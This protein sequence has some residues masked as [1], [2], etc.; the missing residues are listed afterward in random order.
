MHFPC[1]L[2]ESITECWSNRNVHTS[3]C[4]RN[5]QLRPMVRDMQIVLVMIN[6]QL[7]VDHEERLVIFFW[8]D[9]L[10]IPSGIIELH[11]KA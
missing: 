7:E 1:L 11:A 6:M 9:T 2:S 5:C 4:Q 10:I 8:L 3:S